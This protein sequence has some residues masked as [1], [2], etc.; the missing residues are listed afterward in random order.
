MWNTIF[1]LTC[2]SEASVCAVY[3]P[4]GVY[5]TGMT[6]LWI[7]CSTTASAVS[8]RESVQVPAC[9]P[10]F[11][12]MYCNQ[13]VHHGVIDMQSSLHMAIQRQYRNR[14]AVLLL[15]H[16]LGSSSEGCCLMLHMTLV[17]YGH[18]WTTGFWEG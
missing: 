5:M 16:R 11:C 9:A 2:Q 10:S 1:I 3:S 6:T 18:G 7:W 15:P 17:L 4:E 13:T 8:D 14:S 12:S